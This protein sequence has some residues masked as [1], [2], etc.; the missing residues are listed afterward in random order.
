MNEVVPPSLNELARSQS[1]FFLATFHKH[2]G[3]RD[4]FHFKR[5]RN[6]FVVIPIYP[7]GIPGVLTRMDGAPIDYEVKG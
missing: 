7:I 6:Y 2:A 3:F 5:V 4:F 1:P